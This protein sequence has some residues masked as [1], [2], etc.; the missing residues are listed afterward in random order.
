VWVAALSIGVIVMCDVAAGAN[1]GGDVAANESV[2]QAQGMTWQ[3]TRAVVSAGCEVAVDKSSG[4]G[5]V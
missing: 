5:G 3:L 4:G 2:G 1:A